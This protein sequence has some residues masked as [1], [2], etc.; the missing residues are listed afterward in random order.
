VDKSLVVVSGRRTS[1]T[2]FDLLETMRAYGRARL[3]QR[4]VEHS[5]RER[6]ARWFARHAFEIGVPLWGPGEAERIEELVGSLDNYRAAFHHLRAV[7]R[8][9]V[10]M[11][12]G[13]LVYCSWAL[14]YEPMQWAVSL[15]EEGP[16]PVVATDTH[17]WFCAT[18]AWA[19]LT[20]HRQDLLEA[21]RRHVA[22]TGADPAW[23]PVLEIEHAV[24]GART[25][26]PRPTALGDLRVEAHR[27]VERAE[28]SGHAYA[29][30]FTAVQ[31]AWAHEQVVAQFD[32]AVQIA[33]RANCRVVMAM[34]LVVRSLY[35]DATAPEQVRRDLARATE[36]ADTSGVP[37]VSNLARDFTVNA[38]GSALTVA[39]RLDTADALLVSWHRAADQTRVF[40]TL[41]T[42]VTL[43]DPV[44]SAEDVVVLHH[45][46]AHRQ[47]THRAPGVQ[48]RVVAKAAAVRQ[49]VPGDRLV[50][51]EHEAETAGNGELFERGRVALAR[52]RAAA[53]TATPKPVAEGGG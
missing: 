32:R 10:E 37:F 30:A 52:A 47:V 6:H 12:C 51:L 36:I 17:L 19:A 2:R 13:G 26:R 42:I 29:R 28:A 1:E 49:R 9:E 48:G 15:W 34:A 45:A 20:F 16:G 11:L 4:D 44:T 38:T 53:E 7:D 41:A 50:Q 5:V 18:V 24:W 22:E 25:Y 35:I 31:T 46:I 21:V 43:L 39:E 14:V 3:A 8:D 23:L 40:N 33:E 27:Q